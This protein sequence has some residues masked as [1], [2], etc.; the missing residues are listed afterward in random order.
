MKLSLTS[1]PVLTVLVASALV[2][3]AAPTDSSF[4]ALRTAKVGVNSRELKDVD[5]TTFR[6]TAVTV[7][8]KA[9][10]GASRTMTKVAYTYTDSFLVAVA[11]GA[12]FVMLVGIVIERLLMRPMANAPELS[13]V[14]VFIGMLLAIEGVT[15]AGT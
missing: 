10:P 3:C 13:S 5:P 1:L 8:D 2:A 11:A 4:G 12:L 9:N 14:G 6:K 15:A 7:I